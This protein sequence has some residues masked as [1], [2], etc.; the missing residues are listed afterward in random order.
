MEVK[1]NVDAVTY[2]RMLTDQRYVPVF[3]GSDAKMAPKWRKLAEWRFLREKPL[4][5]TW[6]CKKKC[7]TQSRIS[8][9]QLISAKSLMSPEMAQKWRK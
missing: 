2:T 3:T 7:W 1:K 5:K 9:Y 4:K 6:K 8:E